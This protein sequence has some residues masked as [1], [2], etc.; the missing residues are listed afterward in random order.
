M[1]MVR[2]SLGAVPPFLVGVAG[3]VAFETSAGLLLYLDQGLLPALTLVLTVEVGALG[4]G[5]WSS[6]IP[7]GTGA[8]EQVRRRWL[9]SL[10]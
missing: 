4:L 2:V 9:F 3:A 6:S 7:V 8:I 1:T 10:E 5:L